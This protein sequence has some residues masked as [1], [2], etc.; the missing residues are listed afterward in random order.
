MSNLK[1]DNFCFLNLYEEIK[2]AQVDGRAKVE[3]KI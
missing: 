3:I 1:C 2:F